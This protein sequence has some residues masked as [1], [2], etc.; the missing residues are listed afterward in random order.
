MSK[1]VATFSN[2]LTDEYKGKRDVKAAWMVVLPNGKVMTGHSND[3]ATAH[4]TASAKAAEMFRGEQESLKFHW[5]AL[6][7]ASKWAHAQ[8]MIR[9]ALAKHGFK[10][11]KE[12][13]AALAAARA[14]FVTRCKI[15]V[16]A[17]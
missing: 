4:K 6:K 14:A 7:A 13:D 11:V 12:H 3:I 17:L 8:P 9:A 1:I 5:Q 10:N 2:G 15:E 16:V